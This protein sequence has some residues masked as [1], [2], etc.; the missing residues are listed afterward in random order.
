MYRCLVQNYPNLLVSSRSCSDSGL[1]VDPSSHSVEKAVSPDCNFPGRPNTLAVSPDSKKGQ[2]LG[3]Q[4]WA[5]RIDNTHKRFSFA[6]LK[7]LRVHRL[8]FFPYSFFNM[9][10]CF[11]IVTLTSNYYFLL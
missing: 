6:Y 8:V 11:P 3:K 2:L 10:D 5:K 1:A 9:Y 4:W 7:N